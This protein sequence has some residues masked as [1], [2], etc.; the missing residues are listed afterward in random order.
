MPEKVT[1]NIVIQEGTIQNNKKGLKQP[2]GISLFKNQDILIKID[3][4]RR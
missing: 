1:L 3:E 4:K 2:G